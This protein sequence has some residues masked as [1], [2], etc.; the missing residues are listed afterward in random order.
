MVSEAFLALSAVAALAAPAAAQ[1]QWASKPVEFI[2][3][4]GA[5]GGTDISRT[6]AIHHPEARPVAGAD[7]VQ[8]EGG[9]SGAE[10]YVYTRLAEGDVHKLVFERR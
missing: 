8:I 10:D 3:T 6:R 4:A 9:G 5:G 7:V 1:T 2:V